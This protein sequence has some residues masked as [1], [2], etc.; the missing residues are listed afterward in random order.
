MAEPHEILGVAASATTDEIEA[1]FRRKML[2]ANPKNFE[3]GSA[4]WENATKMQ[5]RLQHAYEALTSQTNNKPIVGQPPTTNLPKDMGQPVLPNNNMQILLTTCI[6]IVVVATSM[7]IV[8]HLNKNNYTDKPIPEQ[9]PVKNVSNIAEKILPATVM[10]VVEDSQGNIGYGSGFFVNNSGDILTNYHVV[11]DASDIKILTNDKNEYKAGIRAVE[12]QQDIALL[13]SNTPETESIPLKILD[14]TPKSG[15]EIIAA[16]APKGL[17]QTISNGIV[18]AI[19][20]S[21]GVTYLQITAPI[22]PG[23]SGGPI[24]NMEGEVIGVST[25]IITSGQN[26]NFAVSSRHLAVFVPY[27]ER[28]QPI[29]LASKKPKQPVPPRQY[30]ARKDSNDKAKYKGYSTEWHKKSNGLHV[31]IRYPA[32]W[33]ALEGER[34]HI[35]QKFIG[36]TVADI[37]PMAL[38]YVEPMALG[39]DFFNDQEANEFLSE[40][41]KSLEANPNIVYLDGKTTK[42][43]GEPAFLINLYSI[44]ERAGIKLYMRELRLMFFYHDTLFMLQC[45]VGGLEDQ[46]EEVDM[47]FE[48]LTP[49]FMEIINSVVI[50]S[51][52]KQ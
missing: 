22:S 28:I 3:Q 6:L 33:E 27:A 43:D 10:I 41:K 49:T 45:M 7:Y 24:V 19:R 18:S 26:L 13:S 17:S 39:E 40:F 23:S 12:K 5:E 51:K 35:V 38:I 37:T 2:Y 42:I 9:Q 11:E 14:T 16:G 52:W 50:H 31:S 32:S 15:I 8:S 34:P 30:T 46:E 29:E 20:E 21:D 47:S 36:R 1:V 44:F 25:L 4:E 48:K